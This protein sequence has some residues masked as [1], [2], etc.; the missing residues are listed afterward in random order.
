VQSLHDGPASYVAADS[1]QKAA[2][3]AMPR[4][5][6][7]RIA[8]PS[9]SAINNVFNLVLAT[10]HKLL[11]KAFGRSPRRKNRPLQKDILDSRPNR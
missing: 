9:A 4:K 3:K 5:G 10:R 11:H 8:S 6:D 7:G 1:P 2:P